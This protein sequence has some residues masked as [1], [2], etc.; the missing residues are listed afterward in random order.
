V[1]QGRA[2]RF[3]A[4][5]FGLPFAS[6]LAA[7]AFALAFVAVGALVLL[8]ERG[9][10][11]PGLAR[12]FRGNPDALGPRAFALLALAAGV[13]TAVRA[14]LSGVVLEEERV[15][16]RTADALGVPRVRVA[17]WAELRGARVEAAH[18]T[19]V[20]YDGS[21]LALP[22]TAGGAAFAEAVR[23]RLAAYHVP[24]LAPSG[25]ATP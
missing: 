16:V 2:G 18:V 9:A 14:R 20:Q 10:L 23:E 1:S 4:K 8:A 17:F 13:G 7:H 22:E 3:T 19:L 11:A 12:L 21:E 15:V 25:P 24:L 6:Q 5:H